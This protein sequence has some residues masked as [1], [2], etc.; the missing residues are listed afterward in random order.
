MAD[1]LTAHRYQGDGG[2]GLLRTEE[3][4]YGVPELFAGDAKLVLGDSILVFRFLSLYI[5]AQEFKDASMPPSQVLNVL[6]YSQRIQRDAETP[7]M[8][9]NTSTSPSSAQENGKS[10]PRPTRSS[11]FTLMHLMGHAKRKPITLATN[12]LELM[13]LN[14]LP[15]APSNEA[16]LTGQFRS[17]DLEQRMEIS[18]TPGLKL[19][20]TVVQQ[21]VQMLDQE[22]VSKYGAPPSS[23][24]SLMDDLEQPKEH[25]SVQSLSHHSLQPFG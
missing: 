19:A 23:P 2:P 4:S 14:E 20:V 21:H 8:C 24:Q 18:K 13:Q 7:E 17:M 16:E 6:Q 15:G 12:A 3:F 11:S 9:R 5:T 25:F 22:R 1:A 10:L